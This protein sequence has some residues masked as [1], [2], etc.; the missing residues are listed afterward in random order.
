M[1]YTIR[2]GTKTVSGLFGEETKEYVLDSK[3]ED[4]FDNGATTIQLWEKNSVPAVSANQRWLFIKIKDN[5]YLI[6]NIANGKLLDAT[7]SCAGGTANC[8]VSTRDAV[9][10]DQT[11]IWILEKA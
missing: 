11:Q 5:K 2:F 4:L 1:G 6:K 9:T 3:A 10:D 7:N 8:G